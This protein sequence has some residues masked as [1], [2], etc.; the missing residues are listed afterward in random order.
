MTDEQILE[1]MRSV[2]QVQFGLAAETITLD[3]NFITDL[4][5]D[6]LDIVE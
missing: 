6:S 5:A 4:D 3:M 1:R 2:I